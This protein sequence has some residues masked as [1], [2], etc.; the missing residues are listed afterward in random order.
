MTS[1]YA[2]IA[3]QNTPD[4]IVP[5]LREAASYLASE[6]YILR[7][8]DTHHAEQAFHQG[9]KDADGRCAVHLPWPSYIG[10][11]TPYTSPSGEAAILA[12]LTCPT[13]LEL[14]PDIQ[15]RLARNMHTLYG[16]SLK[17]PVD[18]VVCWHSD[19]APDFVVRHLVT[20]A[21]SNKIPV[22]NFADRTPEQAAEELA[23]LIESCLVEP[24]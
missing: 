4:H 5:I 23:D 11:S 9:C 10:I 14:T 12:E 20:T 6:G 17:S 1:F 13:W 19:G 2:G 21:L 18:F 7:F 22:I 24:T 16:A 3:A 8:G 15:K